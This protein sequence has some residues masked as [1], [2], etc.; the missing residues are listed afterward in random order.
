MEE[1]ATNWTNEEF[2]AYVLLYAARCDYEE[3]DDEMKIVHALINE[4]SFHKIHKEIEHDNDFVSMQKI[5]FNLDKFHY[6]KDDADLL[7]NEIR[8]LFMSGHN[9]NILENNM[10][11]CLSRILH[12]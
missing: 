3:S 4:G 12:R 11:L 8:E 2:K 5:M 10:L 6:T 7:L 1:I 9:F